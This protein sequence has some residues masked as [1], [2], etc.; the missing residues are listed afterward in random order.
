MQMILKARYVLHG[1]ETQDR[2]T[3]SVFPC[4]KSITLRKRT[5]TKVGASHMFLLL[6]GA[7]T[8]Q[9]PRFNHSESSMAGG[10][11]L[12]HSSICSLRSALFSMDFPC[13]IPRLPIRWD[14]A[15]HS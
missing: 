12:P 2:Q 13:F 3:H 5:W 8:V 9:C 6:A 15:A 4:V 10:L 7:A 14:S 11:S 1:S